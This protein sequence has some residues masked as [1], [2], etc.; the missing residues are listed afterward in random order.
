MKNE[1]KIN[2]KLVDWRA[3]GFKVHE[4]CGHPIVDNEGCSMCM[5]Q[6]ILSLSK[7]LKESK[8]A[9]ERDEKLRVALEEIVKASRWLANSAVTHGAGQFLIS[10]EAMNRL[11]DAIISVTQNKEM[12]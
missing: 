10:I 12:T 9:L 2:G 8:S 7:E 11:R 6:Q 4:P 1:V 3:K 5:L